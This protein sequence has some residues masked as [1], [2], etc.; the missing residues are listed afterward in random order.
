MSNL[1]ENAQFAGQKFLLKLLATLVQIHHLNRRHFLL[2][3][4]PRLERRIDLTKGARGQALLQQVALFLE[5]SLCF[6]VQ[7]CVGRHEPVVGALV[8]GALVVRPRHFGKF[9]EG[10]IVTK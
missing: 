4:G 10:K 2:P 3:I 7:F 6:Q 5:H 8:V 9:L 1:Y